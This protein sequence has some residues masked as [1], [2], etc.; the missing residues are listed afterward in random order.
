MILRKEFY[1]VRHGQTDHNISEGKEKGDHHGDIPL[2]ATGR[3]QAAAIEPMIALLPIL[4]ICTSPMKRAKETKEI[5]SARLPVPHYEINN[6]GECSAKIWGEMAQLG[7]Y[8]PLPVGGEARLFI[9]RVR[10]GIN[11]TLSLPGPV[12]IV[13]HGGV[14]WATCCLMGIEN[15][16][17]AVNNCDLVHFSI[18]EDGK[19]NASKLKSV[20]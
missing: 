15:H 6:L 9:E 13:A 19:W 17:W 18:G 20:F 11:Q 2:N 7:M 5:I 3:N 10:K 1:F 8:S 12:L 4:T 16:A 14:H